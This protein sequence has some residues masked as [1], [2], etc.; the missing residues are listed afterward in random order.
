[1]R[2]LLPSLLYQVLGEINRLVGEWCRDFLLLHAGAVVKDGAALVLP[3]APHGGKSTTV[4]ALLEAGFSYLSDEFG[5]IDPVTQRLF[6]VPR[7]ITVNQESLR[8]FDGLAGRL[9]DEVG[10]LTSFFTERRVRPEDIGAQVA[11]PA[12]LGMLVF[13]ESDHNGSPR[14][15]PIGKAEAVERLARSTFNLH[16]H[17]ERGVILLS[18]VAR[19]GRAYRLLGGTPRARAELLLG[20]F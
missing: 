16:R 4:L 6:P 1:M 20:L 3:A 17:G 14:L 12:P 2:G 15:D 7:R 18:R 5:A 10:L 13:P 19:E 9:E 11:E 8:F